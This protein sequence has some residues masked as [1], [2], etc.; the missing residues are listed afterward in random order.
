METLPPQIIL[1]VDIDCATNAWRR[2]EEIYHS[3][4]EAFWEDKDRLPSR[5]EN[6]LQELWGDKL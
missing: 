2:Y 3:R 5:S 6:V 4:D 1:A